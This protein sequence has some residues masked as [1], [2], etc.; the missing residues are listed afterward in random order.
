[1]DDTK[2]NKVRYKET[3]KLEET[4]VIEIQGER[5][6]VNPLFWWFV[7]AILFEWR[8]WSTKLQFEEAAC[9]LQD[10]LHKG[11]SFT[12]D[13]Y[14]YIYEHLS[15]LQ[16]LCLFFWTYKFRVYNMISIRSVM[17]EFIDLKSNV[18]YSTKWLQYYSFFFWMKLASI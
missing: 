2:E 18:W 1:M 4:T 15:H 5:S 12:G 16:H 11:K 7:V 10:R 14:I 9:E 6:E 3:F 13:I 17:S 8:V